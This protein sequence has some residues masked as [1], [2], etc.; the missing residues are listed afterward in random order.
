MVTFTKHFR[1]NHIIQDL[2]NRINQKEGIE[3]CDIG[4]SKAKK[5]GEENKNKKKVS[6]FGNFSCFCSGGLTI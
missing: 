5:G 1:F 2:S 4:Y 3:R 6:H